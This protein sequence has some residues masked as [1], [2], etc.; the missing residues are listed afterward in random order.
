M[1]KFLILLLFLFVSN[2]TTRIVLKLSDTET[3]VFEKQPTFKKRNVVQFIGLREYSNPVTPNRPQ[4]FKSTW[5]TSKKELEQHQ[6]PVCS[7]GV[8]TIVLR[9]DGW[10]YL[11]HFFIGAF[12]SSKSIE[13]YCK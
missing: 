7:S 8:E 10:D 4:K 3:D 2:C 5:F 12:N 11:Q 6:Q 1:K 9:G 13:V